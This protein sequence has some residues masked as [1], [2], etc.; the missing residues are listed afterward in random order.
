MIYP[1][2][3]PYMKTVT[4]RVYLPAGEPVGKGNLIFLFSRS[5]QESMD[6]INEKTTFA[7]NNKY[8][9]YY[10]NRMYVGKIY[11]KRY[12]YREFD[13]QK[14]IYDTI[15][16][17]T[18]LKRYPT[19]IGIRVNET[20]NTYFDLFRYINILESRISNLQPFK[21][22]PI[23]WRYLNDILTQRYGEFDHKYLLINADQF[24]NIK[25]SMKETISNPLFMI[26]FTLY[27]RFDLIRNFTNLDIDILI[28]RRGKVLKINLAKCNEKSYKDFL[29]QMKRIY[30]APFLDIEK[31][32]ENK[33]DE[34]LA[35]DKIERSIE[36]SVINHDAEPDNSIPLPKIAGIKSIAH[37]SKVAKNS[38]SDEIASAIATKVNKVTE[39]VKKEFKDATGDS[40]AV[41]D[42]DAAKN[43]INNKVKNEIED[44]KEL[45]EKIY[46]NLKKDTLPQKSQASTARDEL[47]R[48]KQ[49]DIMIKDL[50]L[51]DIEK[52]K[53][54]E[55]KIET[56][57]VSNSVHTTNKNMTNIKFNNFE[58]SYNEKMLNK[59]IMGTFLEL[60]SKSIPMFLRDVKIEDS[61][62]R[63][64]Y[65]DT[66]T[67]Y[68]EDG[69]RNRHTIVVDIPKFIEDRFL[70]IG[71]NKKLI[72]HQNFFLPI[73][74]TSPSKVQIVSNANKMTIERV[75]TK[76]LM[77]IE[78]L[79]KA[80]E[81]SDGLKSYFTFNNCIN[82]NIGELSVIEIDEFSK[83]TSEF[84]KG[85]VHLIFDIKKARALAESRKIQIPKGMIFIG[86]ENGNPVFINHET[87]EDDKDRSITSIIIST[88]SE[89]E[90]AVYKSIKIPKRLMY[91]KVTVM[92]KEVAVMPLIC[93]WEGLTTV[94]KKSGI[95]YRLVEKMSEVNVG[96]PYI[97]FANCIMIYEKSIYA[98][99][100]LNG[101]RLL[102]TSNHDISYFDSQDAYIDYI[103]KVY[104]KLNIINALENTH[105]FMLDHITKETLKD[106]NLPTDLVEL[107]CYAVKLLSDSQYKYQIDQN[108][109]RVRSNEIIPAILYEKISKAYVLF[110][111]SNGRKK[112]S[113]P[114]DCVIK[115]VLAQKTVEDVSDLNPMLE[116]ERSH[117]VTSKGWRGINLDR[118]YTVPNRCYDP[119]M[120]GIIGPST[121]PDGQV[122]VQ[123]TLSLEPR[124]KTVRGYA[125]TT[126]NLDELKDVNL[127]SP[128]ELMVPLGVTRDDPTRTGHAI[129]QS[130]HVIPVKNASPV[131]ISNGSEETCR[132]YL[133]STFVVNA[134]QDGVVEEYDEVTKIMIVSYKDGSHQAIDLGSNIV[135][136]GGGG[137]FLSNTLVTNLK[138]GDKFKAND[139]LAW[140]K[141]FF[142]NSKA[143]GTRFNI[144]ALEKVALMSTY[145]T[146]N[147]STFITQKLAQD[148]ITEMCFCKQAVL[149]K[150]SNIYHIVKVG[151]HIKVGDPLIHFDESFEE[152]DLNKLL[153]SLGDKEEEKQEL[154]AGSRNTIK[155]KYS[156]VIEDI[157]IYSTVDV[158][159]LSPS[160]GKVVSQYYNKI[161]R[162][163]KILSKYD[164][165]DS[166]VKCG[167]LLKDSSDKV[168]PNKYGVIKGQK[169]EEGVLIEFYIKHEEPLEVGSKIAMFTGL[170]NT[171]GE[172]IEEGYEPY[173][174]FRP[175]EE[176]SSVIASN[177]IL[178]RMVPS[179][180]LTCFG[181]KCIIELKRKLQDIW[182]NN[183]GPSR[184]NTMKNLIY[185]FFTAFDKSGENT[186]KYKAI[187]DPMSDVQFD[188]FFR[189][190]FN[191]DKQYLIL[192]IVDYER[193][194][195]LE[196]IERAAKVLNIPL[197]E[198][199][200]M[201]WITMDKNNIIT[202][203]IKVPVGYINIKRTQQTVAKKNGVSTSID[204]RSAITGQ[205]SGAD[206]NGRESDLE[207]TMLVSLGL[208]NTLKELNSARADD[209]VMKQQM[210]KSISEKGY[211]SL[212]ELD[213]NIENKTT[214]NTFN[215]YLLGMGLNSDLVTK[216]LK[217][218]STLKKE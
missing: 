186:K 163:D 71:G 87:G 25:G 113:V 92:A 202:T 62:D 176:I 150:N 162:K 86:L 104:G 144:G 189:Q 72:L 160:L 82:D 26:Y 55:V 19:P 120:I 180:I 156:G 47:L 110:K 46:D 209:L 116:L 100:L 154:L 56:V 118:S 66:Y 18:N 182:N 173:S 27:K 165:S 9:Y 213:D 187:F 185:T 139:C 88:F 93:L 123:R 98:E 5:L 42:T 183:K 214:L 197:Y 8:K 199:V 217:L 32:D 167:I 29:I 36:L 76:S 57:D 51:G 168:E 99:L 75:D 84:K 90:L 74:K 114:K 193:S 212:S 12:R 91:T 85:K 43:I 127:F 103:K 69:N 11:N 200:A 164:K 115:E 161:K 195:K 190:F 63:L 95:K 44:D 24:R 169:V 89:A 140:H 174:F 157:K 194:I 132:F 83:F 17:Q 22:I 97:K 59:D 68:L 31:I 53:P 30:S 52:I 129:K 50:T 172:V 54:E 145:D 196:D 117:T 38:A 149:G 6:I 142:S 130:K 81:K 20:R 109:Y 23:F 148:C 34:E 192:D 15:E 2:N 158:E 128:A 45:M 218:M 175:E 77:G 106:M 122:G 37:I 67:F 151:E 155:S 14:A 94:L 159:E 131:L 7:N 101:F 41:V 188:N 181:N 39:E 125:D 210:L 153:A 143:Q 184:K 96:D 119:S 191:D 124:L 108:L 203:K 147:D 141:D 215:T 204:S 13:E 40:N 207:N 73:V 80:I 105:E 112:L 205:V 70:Y 179:V 138:V 58:K 102:E 49:K 60:N 170:K 216:G 201:P 146:Y 178:K 121:S 35:K 152:S 208:N 65:K 10:Y 136:N 211:V 1:E 64:N 3:I 171:I 33:I 4:K 78:I 166:I 16:E 111:N 206:K 21:R 61:S 198:Y 177:S 135:K 137:F 133:S 134:K 79:F 28:Y 48:S 107:V 126:S